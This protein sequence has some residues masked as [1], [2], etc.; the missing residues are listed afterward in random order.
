MIKKMVLLH[1]VYIL[2]CIN[3]YIGVTVNFPMYQRH[4]VKKQT[5]SSSLACRSNVHSDK[6]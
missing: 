3:M 5:E 6:L 1:L 4:K 2:A